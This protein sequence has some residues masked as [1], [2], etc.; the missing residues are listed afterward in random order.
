MREQDYLDLAEHL[1]EVH[2]ILDQFS[3]VH[4]FNRVNPGALG[5]YPRIRIA[6]GDQPRIWFDLWLG[7]DEHGNRFDKFRRDL[8]YDLSCGATVD[9]EERPGQWIRMGKAVLCFKGR[10]FDEVPS[11]LLAEMERELPMLE[12][13]D[14]DYLMKYGQR[15]ELRGSPR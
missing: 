3:R 1:H 11:T 9:L 15:I 10:P 5:R 8:P 13:W 7:E 6:R 4:G 2:P 14:T 12:S